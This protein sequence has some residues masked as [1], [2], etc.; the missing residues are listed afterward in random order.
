MS[1]TLTLRAS[2]SCVVSQYAVNAHYAAPAQ[3]TLARGETM[4][5]LLDL[6]PAA[7]YEF[8]PI[9]SGNKVAVYV[10]SGDYD[11]VYGEV[12]WVR[13]GYAEG[14]ISD[15]ASLT[16]SNGPGFYCLDSIVVS[17]GLPGDG[18]A[19]LSAVDA[20]AAAR[21]GL[22]IENSQYTSISAEIASASA[23]TG[24]KPA[25]K[26]VV[27]ETATV[28]LSIR[29]CSPTSGFV[30]RAQPAVFAWDARPNGSCITPVVQESGFFRWREGSSGQIHTVAAFEDSSVTIPAGTFPSG[31]IQW[32]I[33]LTAN[34]GEVT[35]S[36]WYTITTADAT[37]TA[38]PRS[39]ISAV[40]DGGEDN[41]FVWDHVISTGTAQTA[42]DLQARI[43][44]TWTTI[45]SGTGAATSTVI[46]AGTLSTTADAW[47]VRTYNADSVAG[48]W[49][50]AASIIVVAAPATPGVTVISQGPRPEIRW[51]TTGQQGYEIELGDYASGLIYGAAQSWRCPIWLNDGSYIVRVRVINNYGLWSEW[52]S[53]PVTVTHTEGDAITLTVEATHTAR[54][55][56]RTSGAYDRFVVYRNGAVVAVT[57]DTVYEDPCSIGPVTYQIRGIY[58]GSDDYGLSPE[59]AVTVSA[60]TLM[61]CDLDSGAWLRLELSDAQHRTFEESLQR[62]TAQIYLAGRAYP[63]VEIS[64]H[65]SRSVSVTWATNNPALCAACDALP[66]KRVCVKTPGGRMVTGILDALSRTGGEFYTVYAAT[67]WQIAEEVITGDP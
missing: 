19:F 18:T 34:S 39:P 25:L 33:E 53:A 35:T 6:S 50:D 62:Q 31:E 37:P 32:Q 11:D 56:W 46:P 16:Y 1:K 64:E 5:S 3:T 44:G 23:T 24:R 14:P 21:Y 67:V 66:G 51:A 54:L 4:V 2:E 12:F 48:A 29:S 8:C 45:K 40:L 36:P 43:S 55:A 38:V 27:D 57:G 61:L 65:S 58:E 63:V 13:C 7:G 20:E 9:V 28:G 26:L 49:S 15:F 59:V 17:G 41:T 42:F 10:Y 22:A 47:R 52:G 30:D 60:D